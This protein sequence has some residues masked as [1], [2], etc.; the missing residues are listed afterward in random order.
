MQ[1][2]TIVLMLRMGMRTVWE[3]KVCDD[4]CQGLNVLRADLILTDFQVIAVA[5][6]AQDLSDFII[7]NHDLERFYRTADTF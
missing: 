2:P 3:L 1:R 6:K 4:F 5:G 7:I